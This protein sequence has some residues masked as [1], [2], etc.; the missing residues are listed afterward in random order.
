MGDFGHDSGSLA[1]K[2]EKNEV[3]VANRAGYVR[4]SGYVRV[5][6]GRQ[7]C[8]GTS[9]QV[10]SQPRALEGSTSVLARIK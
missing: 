10:R 7:V 9:G 1:T 5:R 6:Q 2:G 3:N 8:Q 4:S